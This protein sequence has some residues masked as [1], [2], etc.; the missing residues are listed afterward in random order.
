MAR[1]LNTTTKEMVKAARA[2]IEEIDA[3][4]AIAMASNDDVVMVDLRDVRERQRSG[5]VPDS[6]HCPRGMT[7]F[8]VD[9]E[10]P[11]YKE[12]F[13]RDAKFVFYCASGWRSALTVQTLQ[14]M[15]FENAAHVKGGFTAWVEAQGAV[16]KK[17]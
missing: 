7:E 14:T 16:E 17:D 15:G 10:S 13:D 2:Q 8:W 1:K 12:I 3:E 5:F 4:S 11:Y 6:F 9:P